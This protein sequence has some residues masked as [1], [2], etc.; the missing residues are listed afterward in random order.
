M[1]RPPY[2]SFP[3]RPKPGRRLTSADI[4]ESLLVETKAGHIPAGS[5]LPP[6]R[7]LEHQL[8]LSKNTAQAAYDELVAR[9]VLEAREREGVFVAACPE[10]PAQRAAIAVPP[11]P[12]LCDALPVGGGHAPRGMLALSTVFVDPELL[13]RDRLADCARSVLKSQGLAPF[14]DPQGYLPLRE[15]IA[16]RLR[17]RGMDAAASNVII[18][19]GSQQALDLVARA[20]A[21]KRV[22]MESP[23]YGHAKLLFQSLGYSTTALRL[24]PF[25]GIAFEE[26]ESCI[27]RDRPSFFYTVTSFQ[28]PT[29]YSYSSHELRAL[30]EL[31]RAYDVAL[32]EDDWGSDMLS[33]GEYRPMLRLLGGSHVVYL[34]TFTKKLLPSLRIGFLLADASLIPALV[35]V[36]RVSTLGNPWLM[37]AILAEFLD[38]GYYDAHLASLQAELDARYTHC[39]T[40]L[41]ELMPSDVRWTRPGGG[42]ILWVEVPRAIDLSRL[43]AR[44]HERGVSI[45]CCAEAFHGSAHLHGFRLS[46]A[47]PPTNELR[48]GLEIVADEIKKGA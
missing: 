4:V 11:L 41:A 7:V 39:L 2:V 16:A 33:G 12:R 37:E 20:N 26:W 13:P 8:G 24:D 17:A 29:G 22:A 31:A 45:D 34:N 32:V 25:E 5:R 6:V 10:I 23:S 15:L 35:S 40:A 46:Y 18:T 38:R 28:N 30:L 9:G 3:V 47:F 48:R 1:S 44:L 43:T 27:V 19:A 21:V 36:K 42:P 14:Y